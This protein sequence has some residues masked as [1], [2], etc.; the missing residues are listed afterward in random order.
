[1]VDRYYFETT[2]TERSNHPVRVRTRFARRV[3]QSEMRKQKEIGNNRTA[4]ARIRNMIAGLERAVFSLNGSIEA[5][6]EETEIRD[7]S[8][9]AYPVAAKTMGLRRDNIQATIAV[10]S[11][12]LAKINDPQTDI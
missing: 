7:P 3:V 5:V 12:R 2:A 8:N 1:M 11:E 10:L 6:L 9:F 4:V